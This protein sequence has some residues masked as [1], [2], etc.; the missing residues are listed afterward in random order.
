MAFALAKSINP[1]ARIDPS[2][3]LI[4]HA[5]VVRLGDVLC[6]VSHHNTKAAPT[7]K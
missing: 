2:S 7:M 6:D 1:P 5:G 4:A 3:L